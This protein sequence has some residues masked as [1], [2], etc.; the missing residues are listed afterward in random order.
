MDY[1]LTM[2]VLDS[3]NEYKLPEEDKDKFDRIGVLL[4]KMDWDG[5]KAVLQEG[6]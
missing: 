4:T 1:D 2:M 5:I 6:Y 3:V